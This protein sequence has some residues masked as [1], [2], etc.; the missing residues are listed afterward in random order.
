[1]VK[2]SQHNGAET[3]MMIASPGAALHLLSPFFIFSAL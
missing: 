1:M 3:T 2:F